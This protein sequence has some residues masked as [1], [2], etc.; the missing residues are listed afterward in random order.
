MKNCC[1]ATLIY[2]FAAIIPLNLSANERLGVPLPE[3][4]QRAQA[5]LAAPDGQDLPL[6]QA[7]PDFISTRQVLIPLQ[8]PSELERKVAEALAPV[9]LEEEIQQQVAQ[10]VLDQF[11]YQMFSTLPTTFAAVAGI[12]VPLD[13]SV[14][15]GD[16]FIVQIFGSTDVQYTLVVTREGRLLLPEIGAL[17]VAGLSFGEAKILISESISNLRIGVKTV[18]TLA[19]LHAIQVM[20]VGEVT[21]P[22]TFAI[23][24]LS[25]LI[26]TLITTGGVKRTGSLRNI[27]VKRAGQVV[28][29]LD[30]YDLLLKGEDTGN[31][32]LRQGDIVF[33]PPIG[34][35]VGVAGEVHRPAIYEIKDE[36]RVDQILT[37]AGGLLPTAAKSKTQIERITETGSYTLLQADLRATGGQIALK[38]G[39]LIRVLPVLDKMDG[40]VLLSG[41]VLTPGGYQWFKG[42]R[43]SD[44]INSPEILRQGAEYDVALVQREDRQRKRTEVI[45]FDLGQ[46]FRSPGSAADIRLEARDQLLIFDTHSPRAEQLSN[47]VRK[48][49]NEST[50]DSPAKLVEMRG[51]FKHPGIYPLQNAN[52]LLDLIQHSGGIQNGTDLD[53]VLLARTQA[54]T[55]RL[56]FVQLD[57]NIARSNPGGDHNPRIYP[58][59]KIYLFG[60]NSDRAALLQKDIERLRTQTGYGEFAPVVSVTGSVKKAGN[61]PLVPGMRVEDLIKAGGGM[62]EE[63]FGLAATLARHALLQDQFSRI[64]QIDISLTRRDPVLED[65]YTLLKPYDQLV[66]RKKPEWNSAPRVVTIEGEVRYPGSYPVDK[67][68]TLC[69][70]VQRVGGFTEDAYL[71][72]TV[73]LRES[74]R[75]REQEALD[76]LMG[77]MDDLLAEVKLSPGYQKDQKQ[78]ASQETED[79]FRVI[80]QL[81]PSKAAGRLVIDMEAAVG[82]CDEASDLVLEDGDRIR[83]PKYQ[84]EVSVVGQVYFP[85]SHKFSSDRGALDYIS[86]SGGTKELA[87]HEHAYIVQANGQVMTVRSK[88]STWGW[89]L[90]P[91]NVKVTPGS[92]I[93]VPLSVDRINGREFAES[94]VDL[95]YK[96]ALSAASVDYL[97]K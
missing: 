21:Q 24:G 94:W 5:V 91:N 37:L 26:N 93:Y 42:M 31:I 12:G 30:I 45:Y 59:D 78:P 13:Y 11:G 32:Y 9:S 20:M 61:Y 23:S 43:V 25:S 41:H 81:A 6:E 19:E 95:F 48:L 68:E 40:V 63:S 60:P 18:I 35:T 28:A 82:R 36:A 62:R 65:R 52:R 51:Y 55:N 88:A 29:T 27:Q 54:Q 49:R 86:L 73:F 50:V 4:S 46:V 15:P 53:Y 8:A 97:F 34:N 44:L 56:Y 66:L 87:Q 77:Q 1:I 58:A 70:L 80:K 89:L 22:G 33:V 64:D 83:V 7:G 71:F 47:M 14:G 76:R 10:P 96:L 17:Q 57:L 74:V 90:A 79:T 84:D 38:S 72:G 69:G 85:T 16:T 3:E 92:T 39:D 67:R 75:Q 2:V